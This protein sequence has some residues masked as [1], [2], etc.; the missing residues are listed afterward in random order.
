MKLKKVNVYQ[1]AT[2]IVTDD[3]VVILKEENGSSIL[4]III[5]HFE[6]SSIAI[7]LEKLKI[8]R[9]MTHDLIKN[10]LETLGIKIQ[11]IVITELKG[12]TY[13]ATI[14][15]QKDEKLFE[16]DARPSDSIAIAVRTGS[17]IYV[18]E[19]LL[20]NIP[21]VEYSEKSHE[22]K[23]ISSLPED[24]EKEKFKQFLEKIKPT[25]FIKFFQEE[26]KKEDKEERDEWKMYK[27]DIGVFGGTGFYSFLEAKEIIVETPYGAT[28]D[29]IALAEVEGKKVAF[30]PRH[31]KD[32]R[33]PPSKINYRANIWAFK[34]LGVKYIISPCAAGSLQPHIKP[35]DIVILDQIFDATKSR[36]Y[37][38]FE[39]PITTHV[40]FANPYNEYLRNL[41]IEKA[42]KLGLSFHEKGTVVV[43]EGPRFSTKSE[44]KFYSK[45]GFEVINM[46]QMPEAILAREMQ[47][48]FAG[49]ALITD[50]D[51][52]LEGHPEIEP[53]SHKVA[54]ENFIKNQEKMKELILEVIKDIDLTREEPEHRALENARFEIES[55]NL[56]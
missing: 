53:V 5:G 35:G 50:Y 7:A 10:I 21:I 4:P 6:A 25:D 51:V 16:I 24:E 48:P 37:T 32:H 17:P 29:K 39:G 28:S 11:K 30:L 9:P 55:I 44:S 19:S 23:S 18:N 12:S 13:Y 3:A 8:E 45:M 43:I 41:F 49:V 42:K 47:I 54:I 1:L 20:Q 46:T 52:G 26:Q 2:D 22:V 27:A 56:I 34:K 31:G 40:S 33:Y 38:F 36:V 15:L 14:Y